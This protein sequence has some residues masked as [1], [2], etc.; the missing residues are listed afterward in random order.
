M[1]WEGQGH[2]N[3]G[4][5]G[6]V[7]HWSPGRAGPLELWES[8]CLLI[9][10][11]LWS[12]FMAAPGNGAAS[13]WCQGHLSPPLHRAP[14]VG[15]GCSGWS[16]EASRPLF[17]VTVREKWALRKLVPLKLGMRKNF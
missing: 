5:A 9:K 7:L 2:Q 13:N 12:L 16:P 4:E 1:W 3:L 11:S 6:G 10:P 17:T 8:K 15:S 14:A